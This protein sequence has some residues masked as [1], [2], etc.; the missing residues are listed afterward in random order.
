M[1]GIFFKGLSTIT[2]YDSPTYLSRGVDAGPHQMPVFLVLFR[3]K[4][5]EAVAAVQIANADRFHVAAADLLKIK[6]CLIILLHCLNMRCCCC[7]CRLDIYRG[8]SCSQHSLTGYSGI[9]IIG[10]SQRTEKCEAPNIDTFHCVFR[11]VF[12]G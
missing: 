1:H 6:P 7:C 11:C 5:S 8:V 9:D 4:D 3:R 12:V 10:N 2:T